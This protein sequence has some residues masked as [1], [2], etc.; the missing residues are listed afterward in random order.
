MQPLFKV[1]RVHATEEDRRKAILERTRKKKDIIFGAQSIKAQTGMFSRPTQ[2]FDIF[3][4]NPKKS[5]QEIEKKLDRQ[6]GFN[7]FYNKPA[8]HPGTWKVKGIGMDM[9]KGT[10]DDLEIIDYSKHPKPK[11]KIK[12]INGVRYRTLR[13]EALA[14]LKALRD[15]EYKFRHEKD[16]ED[17]R[18]IRNFQGFNKPIKLNYRKM[19]FKFPKI[20]F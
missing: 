10:D 2:D 14:K 12:K 7:Y 9:K 19:K 4:T 13:E 18:R 1:I 6:V 5:A 3:T 11:P 16:A 17:L 15:P 20:K 8:L